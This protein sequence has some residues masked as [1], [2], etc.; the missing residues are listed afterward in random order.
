VYKPNKGSSW[1]NEYSKFKELLADNRIV[2]GKNG[3]AGPQR[4]RFLYE[5]MGR[6]RAAT[7]LG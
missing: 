7:T 1:K 2:F 4:K 5:A 3:N 6:G